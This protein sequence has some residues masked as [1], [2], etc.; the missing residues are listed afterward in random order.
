[1]KLYAILEDVD[2]GYHCI[3]IFSDPLTAENHMRRLLQAKWEE[4]VAQKS[5]NSSETPERPSDLG[6]LFRIYIQEFVLDSSKEVDDD[7][8][9]RKKI[10]RR[11]NGWKNGTDEKA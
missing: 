11:I 1:M 8:L 5:L 3:G 10:I 4:E 2:L 7:I 6:S 9:W